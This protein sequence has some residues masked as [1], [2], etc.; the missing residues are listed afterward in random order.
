MQHADVG[1]P[2]LERLYELNRTVADSR[3]IRLLVT[4]N[5]AGY[6]TLMERHLDRGAKL[7][8]TELVVR[9]ERDLAAMGS[10]NEQSGL[11]L[12]KYWASQGWLHRITEQA[13][14]GERNVCYLTY[15]AR[16]V[17]DFAR[18]MRRE[19]TIA[20]GGSIAGVAA[21]LRR[22]AGQ[23]SNDPERIRAD[24]E[25]EIEKLQAELDALDEG[26]RPEPNPLDVEDEARA[27]A[28]QMEQIISDI[29][30][31]GSML[32][33]I[34]TRLLDSSA[35]TD[36]GYR[37]RQRQLFDDYESLFASR[38]SA[39][40][41]AFTRMVQDPEQ[42]AGLVADIEMV[43]SQLPHLDPGLREVM[44][45]FFTL[46]SAQT[47]EV[48]RT[49]QRCARRIK[50][51]VASGTLE[52]S[53]GVTRQLNDALASAHDLLKVSLADSRV[54]LE[55]PL[56]RADFNSIGAVAFKIRDAVPPT[57]AEPSDGEVNLSAFAALAAQ[58][59]ATELADLVN[60]AVERGPLPLP[61]AIGMLD[62]AYLGH[63]IVLWS[64]ALKQPHDD[65]I[66]TVRV[67]F[68]SLEGADREI[69]VPALVFTEPIPIVSESLL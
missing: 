63:V 20:T 5:L 61:E 3:S 12:I 26:R 35:D 59:D 44:T 48:G 10:D 58:V 52:E 50:R 31:Y 55:V 30:Q 21:G 37:E 17:L 1:R 4:N 65:G 51:F 69:E 54:G 62:S 23:V 40:Y 60:A 13:G 64:W 39:S 41:T 45:G 19:D 56:A 47:A 32:N 14:D 46:V 42:R 11:Q 22:V 9:L 2:S 49:R 66:E 28:L 43:T 16:A 15:E 57:P 53:R 29:G 68:Q 67:R 8:E 34:T 38:E 25:Q 18:R 6:L 27:I 24:I 36:L 7:T 33:R